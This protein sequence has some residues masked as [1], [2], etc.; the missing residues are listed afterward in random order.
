MSNLSVGDL[1]KNMADAI[2][3]LVNTGQLP[4][5]SKP[6]SRYEYDLRL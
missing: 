6:Y 4:L 3:D 2:Q 5:R 1:M